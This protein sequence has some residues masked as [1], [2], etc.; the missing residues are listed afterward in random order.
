MNITDL[1][2]KLH[3]FFQLR[4][5]AVGVA[6]YNNANV[7]VPDATW[8]SIPFNQERRDDA[9]FHST[10]TNNDRIT[11]PSHLGGWYAIAGHIRWASAPPTGYVGLRV[12]GTTFIAL[13]VLTGGSMMMASV[14]TLY[15]LSGGD[16]IELRVWQNSGAALDIVASGN[17]SPRLRAVRVA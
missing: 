2:R 15:S 9:D 14:A 6:I 11:I 13:Q 17:Y 1:V 10:T 4:S 12:N 5:E 8:T 16:Y 7:S 3:P